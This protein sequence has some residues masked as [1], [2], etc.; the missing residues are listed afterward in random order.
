MSSP[1]SLSS[2]NTG[3]VVTASESAW[4]ILRVKVGDLGQVRL[5]KQSHKH[6][7]RKLGFKISNQVR[8][9]LHCAATGD[10]YKVEISDLGRRNCTI[11]V[12]KTNKPAKLIRIGK[13]LVFQWHG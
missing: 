1:N 8:H 11:C 6:D 7:V 4:I 13:N 3:S 9:K 12:A 5:K 10:G 2:L